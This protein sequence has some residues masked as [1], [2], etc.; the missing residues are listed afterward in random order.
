V[1]DSTI[2]FPTMEGKHRYLELFFESLGV[3]RRYE[4]VEGDEDYVR[5]VEKY[6]SL[7]ENR[8]I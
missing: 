4:K 7:V 6:S 3:L 2:I 1:F 5:L 8:R